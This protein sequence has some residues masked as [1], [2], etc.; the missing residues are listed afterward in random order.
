MYEMTEQHIEILERLH[1]G[2]MTIEDID[3]E[4][5]CCHKAELAQLRGSGYV[6]VSNGNWYITIKGKGC[7]I[8]Y[9]NK[10][11]QFRDNE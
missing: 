10:L 5:A 4:W 6:D 1:K 8:E 7:R 3:G 9:R 2:S 11:G